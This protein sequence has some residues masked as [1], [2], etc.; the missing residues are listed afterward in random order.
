MA[1]FTLEEAYGKQNPQPKPAIN[2][3]LVNALV[4]P[5]ATPNAMLSPKDQKAF[6]LAEAKR[7]AELQ[8]KI[9]E[10]NRATARKLEEEKRAKATKLEEEQRK[11]ANPMGSITEGERKAA[12]LLQRLQFSQQQL[13][14]V[15]QKNPDATKPE[16]LPTFVEGFSETGANLIRSAPRQQIETAQMDLLD[17]ALTL[18]TGASYTKEQLKGYRESYF[19]QI[20]DSPNTIKDKEARLSNIVEAAKIAAGR[21]AKLVPEVKAG[22]K[23]PTGAPPDAKQAPDGKWYSPDPA[24]KGK[25]LQWGG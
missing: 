8:S 17:A 6:D 18:G 2:P 15:L 22:N 23:P 20:G 1:E 19:P 4:P 11:E 12:T 16:Y 3:A 25:Y 5:A 24:R 14:D 9:A 7:K 21:A 13:K 10:E